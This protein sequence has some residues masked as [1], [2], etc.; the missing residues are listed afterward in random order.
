MG[1]RHGRPALVYGVGVG[2]S[3]FALMRGQLAWFR[4]RGWDVT[5]ACSPDRQA[6]LA[7]EREG[8]AFH[9]IPTQRAISLLADLRTLRLW[10][11]FLRS[12]RPDAVNVGTPKAGLLGGL[13]AWALRVPK[14]LYVCRGLRLEGSSGPLALVLWVMER[15][16]TAVATDVVV[17]S[18]SLADEL[19]AR[20]L[21]N[22]RKAWLIGEGSSNGVDAA[23]IAARA[24]A[25]D[26][27][28]L[29]AEH[30]IPA[31]A[32][33]V[34][35]VGRL[36]PDKG[37]DTL[38]AALRQIEV[39]CDVHLVV[40]GAVEDPGV[41]ARLATLGDRVHVLGWTSDLWAKWPILDVLCLPTRREGFPNV[42]LEAAAAGIPTVTT[43]ATG[44]V[45]SVVDGVTGFLVNIDDSSSLARAL[46]RLA[47]DHDLRQQMGTRA[48]ERAFDSFSPQRIWGGLEAL[49]DGTYASP[50]LQRLDRLP[51]RDARRGTRAASNRDGDA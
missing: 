35:F 51:A 43:R 7:V 39:A 8:I 47:T 12:E 20:H 15:L 48:R 23:T 44:A 46:T 24:A 26:S 45:D 25:I 14:R 11:S 36:A 50:D 49:L 42:V 27:A 38:L 22:A 1:S 33:T 10:V 4:E 28:D 40:I 37:V 5:L 3:A 19:L 17:V 21:V 29:R 30:G 18:R 34:G 31:A 13:A 2:V 9:A 41:E 16:S 32:V 6:A